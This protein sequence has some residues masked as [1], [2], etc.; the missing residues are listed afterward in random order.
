MARGRDRGGAWEHDTPGPNPPL[1]CGASPSG[2][3][4]GGLKPPAP[5]PD[6]FNT[7]FEKEIEALFAGV[8]ASAAARRRK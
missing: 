3:D 1:A 5:V 7:L 2:L 8:S 6:N 4:F